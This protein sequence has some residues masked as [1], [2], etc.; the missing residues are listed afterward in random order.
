MQI[1]PFEIVHGFQTQLP[2]P[3][4][5]EDMYFSN[6]NAQNYAMWLRNAI[7]ILHQTVYENLRES[8]RR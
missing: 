5:A 8:K 2:S 3:L 6:E 7:K 4:I 1:T